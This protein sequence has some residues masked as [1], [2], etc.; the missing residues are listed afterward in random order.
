M[1]TVEKDGYM[2]ER[3]L[4]VSSQVYKIDDLLRVINIIKKYKSLIINNNE[5]NNDENKDKK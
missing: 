2:V 1:N 5:D 3:N 4:L